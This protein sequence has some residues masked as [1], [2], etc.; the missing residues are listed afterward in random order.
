MAK[1][2]RS[3]TSASG[4]SLA[5]RAYQAV[6]TAIEEGELA[7]GHRISEYRVADWLKISRTP[8]REGLQRL[9]AEGLLMYQPRR[10]LVVASMDL[11]S[12]KEL[13]NSR[14]IVESALAQLAAANASGPEIDLIVNHA[15]AEPALIEERDKMYQHNKTF[16]QLIRQAAHNRYLTRFAQMME[17]AV[18]AD[19]RGSSLISADRR[20]AVLKEHRRL[21]D[22]IAS[23]DGQ[24]AAQAA[25]DHV[26]AAYDARLSVNEHTPA[27]A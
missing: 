7:P 12:L 11:E 3:R 2:T 20:K 14:E 6:R 5:Q 8:A 17:D 16:H 24:A 23:R 21:A 4:G 18:A 10:G 26:R 9:E 22:A 15:D 13:F 1:S 25:R 19:R 27:E